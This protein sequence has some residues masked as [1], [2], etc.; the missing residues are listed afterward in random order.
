[1]SK[2]RTIFRGPARRPR[3]GRS[4]ADRGAV[5]R[6]S[7]DGLDGGDLGALGRVGERCVVGLVGSARPARGRGLG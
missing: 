3:W 2:S 6:D 7:A 1:M 4:G 5:G